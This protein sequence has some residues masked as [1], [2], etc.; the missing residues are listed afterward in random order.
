M[1]ET[2]TVTVNAATM[3][4][5]DVRLHTV[6]CKRIPGA[7]PGLNIEGLRDSDILDI[8]SRVRHALK[9]A[10][11][12]IRGTHLKVT[13]TPHVSR[14]ERAE[15][16]GLAIAV[17]C[18]GAVSDNDLPGWV[19]STYLVGALDEN[20][21]LASMNTSDALAL[22]LTE[23]GSF[24]MKAPATINAANALA[25][26]RFIESLSDVIHADQSLEQAMQTAWNSARH[27]LLTVLTD[28][29]LEG[30]ASR[31][32]ACASRITDTVH[33]EYRAEWARSLALAGA[34]T[35]AITKMLHEGERPIVVAPYTNYA[36]LFGGGACIRA[37]LLSRAA[38]GTLVFAGSEE[39]KGDL[40]GELTRVV[41]RGHI[42]LVRTDSA[43]LLPT[44]RL[45]VRLLD[46]R[47]LDEQTT[48][49]L[50]DSIGS[51]NSP[52]GTVIDL[53]V[54]KR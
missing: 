25:R 22:A 43:L 46:V 51:T 11:V 9:L 49:A 28:G 48:S 2:K 26:V 29:C 3:T 31:V 54:T 44:P 35:R 17:A 21:E 18:A 27:T 15:L 4:A 40:V 53:T 14:L 30:V 52:Y 7:I 20:G 24:A 23:K 1:S 45:V 34:D 39:L 16:L 42:R 13:V 41:E 33:P 8:R 38:R 5:T 32:S 10:L 50:R 19:T 47:K 6:T 12:D 37:G 36:A